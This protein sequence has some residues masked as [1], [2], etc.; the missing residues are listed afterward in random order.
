MTSAIDRALSREWFYS[1]ELP[2]GRKTPTY[3]PDDVATI[4]TTRLEMIDRILGQEV[5]SPSH[6]TC[7]D[8]ACHEGY[9]AI[10]MA[11]RG[12]RSVLGIDVRPGNIEGAELMREIY[13]LDNVRFEVGDVATLDRD[14]LGGFDIVLV[15]GLLYHLSDPV[16]ALA[17]A[18]SVTR[19]VCLVETQIAPNLTGMI[20]WGSYRF[21]QR[22]VGTYAI[23]DEQQEVR[24]A[25]REA[26]TERVSLVPSLEA[27]LFTMHAVGFAR[28]EVIAPAAGANEQFIAGKR[29]MVS[30]QVG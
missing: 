24:S 12:L 22:I 14:R 13:G 5:H 2:D 19:Q 9:F 8:L 30:G 18:R 17:L 27:L 1:F 10:H 11:R 25:N 4:H 7:L 21:P 29:V 6:A 15:L 16:G 26:N 23:V 28:V 3:L 20:D